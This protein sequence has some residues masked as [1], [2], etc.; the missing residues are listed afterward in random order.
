MYL[1]SKN[2]RESTE[3]GCDEQGKWKNS[4]ISQEPDSEG[5]TGYAKFYEKVVPTSHHPR[6]REIEESEI[7][8]KVWA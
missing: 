1:H 2:S 6:M 3:L 8:A 5:P 4:E 7:T